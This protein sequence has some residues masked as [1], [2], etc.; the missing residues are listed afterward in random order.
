VLFI[1]PRSGQHK[2]AADA[3]ENAD[4]VKATVALTKPITNGPNYDF[5]FNF[6]KAGSVTVAVPISAPDGPRQNEPPGPA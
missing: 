4:S 6:E 2:K 1:G 5:T 3:V